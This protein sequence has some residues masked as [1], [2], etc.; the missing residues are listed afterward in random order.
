VGGTHGTFTRMWEHMASLGRQIRVFSVVVYTQCLPGYG[1]VLLDVLT[2]I[3]EVPSVIKNS[4][5]K[6]R[7]IMIQEY[8]RP[9]PGKVGI[10]VSF[11]LDEV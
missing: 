9:P 7:E 4:M 6:L 2:A 8:Q 3:I 11:V 1:T 5:R 10:S